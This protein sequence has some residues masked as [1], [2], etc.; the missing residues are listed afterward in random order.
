M[1]RDTAHAPQG[2]WQ[3]RKQPVSVLRT[4]PRAQRTSRSPRQPCARRSPVC[5]VRPR[6]RAPHTARVQTTARRSM[7]RPQA[8]SP[9]AGGRRLAVEHFVESQILLIGCSGSALMT[10]ARM[11]ATRESSLPDAR[12]TSISG[13][14]AV[15]PTCAL[16]RYAAGFAPGLEAALPDIAN[17]ADDRP[18]PIW[19]VRRAEGD[20]M[21]DRAAARPMQLRKRLVDHD[22]FRCIFLIA[23]VDAACRRPAARSMV[24]R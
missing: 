16:T 13:M 6:T 5:A 24:A 18:H 7:R 15:P 21:A 17:H 11:G 20:A 4:R 3:G 2:P 1:A 23:A 8:M 12:T 19:I 9:A 10:A 22:D 14:K